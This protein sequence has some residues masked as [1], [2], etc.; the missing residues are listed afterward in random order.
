MEVSSGSVSSGALSSTEVPRGLWTLLAAWLK[1]P[2][3]A[4]LA[5][6][7]RVVRK[8]GVG[9]VDEEDTR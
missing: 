5:N 3:M 9:R 4:G 8:G 2:I 1:K 7:V 6:V